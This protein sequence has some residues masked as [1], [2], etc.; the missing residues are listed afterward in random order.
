MRKYVWPLFAI[1]LSIIAVTIA[2][3][4]NTGAGG[5]GSH[6]IQSGNDHIKDL[7]LR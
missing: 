4:E 2:F 1:A 7:K 6:Q 3:K 5:S